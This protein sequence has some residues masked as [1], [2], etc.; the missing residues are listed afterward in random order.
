MTNVKIAIAT[1]AATMT[2]VAQENSVSQPISAEVAEETNRGVTILAEAHARER[3][4]AITMALERAL[5]Q[6]DGVA[7]SFSERSRI[8][9]SSISSSA[10]DGEDKKYELKDS[11]EKMV[12][13]KS[14]GRISG[15]DIISDSFD[16]ATKLWR[17]K[18]NVRFPG[19]YVVGRDPDKLRRLAVGDF[20]IGT[21]CWRWNGKS[22][23]TAKWRDRF[24][25]KLTSYLTQTRKFTVLDRMFT[26]DIDDELARL[27]ASNSSK[28]D[29][30]RYN[31]KLVTDY[32]VVGSIEFYDVSAQEES[33]RRLY[34]TGKLFTTLQYR[35]L[36]AP[37][38]Q[39]KWAGEVTLAA[40]DFPLSFSDVNT[41]V[42]K[43]T[44]A[45]AKL[46]AFAIRDSILPLEIVE[47]RDGSVVIGEGGMSVRK[48]DVFAVF[49]L[50]NAVHDT[51]TREELDLTE[52][53]IGK[54][55]IVD[56]MPKCSYAKVLE[57]SIDDMQIGAR[58]RRIESLN[59][60]VTEP[61]TITNISEKD[62]KLKDRMVE[63]CRLPL[64]CSSAYK[65]L[66]LCKKIESR[67]LLQV[68]LR[69]TGAAL[70]IVKKADKYKKM[71]RPQIS[72]ASSFEKMLL[73]KCPVC[74][75]KKVVVSRC[76]FC[77]GRGKC[78]ICNNG[79]RQV[80]KSRGRYS[81][82]TAVCWD[83]CLRCNGTGRCS[84]CRGEG[85]I[86]SRCG[87][88]LGKGEIYSP[89]AAA[90]A[91]QLYKNIILRVFR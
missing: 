26:S 43:T 87:C 57:G 56:V 46:I 74:K 34:D 91:Y 69:V 15:F 1:I 84:Y 54:V 75:G 52:E 58:L 12:C 78:G 9:Q 63:L 53:R 8:T 50:G 6:H 24:L 11:I 37:T 30:N 23:S 80:T 83:K 48:G 4:D 32:L 14:D 41:F 47:K 85:N 18:L 49:N 59:G 44:D 62:K 65:W 71:V 86:S 17:V 20:K 81:F 21:D 10:S 13:K 90:E 38:G 27:S 22:Q 51:R 88:C 35:V 39:V 5:L 33:G 28:S 70:L 16:P 2:L 7:M 76:S 79:Y 42:L 66:E 29:V 60:S 82:A 45:A 89:A 73:I 36:L 55:E 31:R 19:K 67:E 3:S 68:T 77:S 64:D 25:G 61:V 72:E 40:A